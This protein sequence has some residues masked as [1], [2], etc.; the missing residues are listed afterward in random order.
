M[1]TRSTSASAESLIQY[2]TTHTPILLDQ[3]IDVQAFIARLTAIK[4]NSPA[5]SPAPSATKPKSQKKSSG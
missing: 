3:G 2:L 5:A 1:K 4:H